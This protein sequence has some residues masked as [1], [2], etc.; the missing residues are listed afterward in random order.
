MDFESLAL[1]F[2]I[3]PLEQAAKLKMV[4]AEAVVVGVRLI[5]VVADFA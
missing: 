4:D 2:S 1:L 5:S 3:L